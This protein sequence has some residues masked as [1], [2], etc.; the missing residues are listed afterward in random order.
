MECRLSSATLAMDP[1]ASRVVQRFRVAT[2][3]IRELEITSDN[4]EATFNALIAGIDNIEE[5]EKKL[6]LNLRNMTTLMKGALHNDDLYHNGEDVLTHIGWVIDDANRLSANMDA[7]KRVLMK[8]TALCHDL[9]KAYTHAW[10]PDRQKHTFHEHGTKS[11]A[12][13]E[14]LLAK[15]KEQLG[16]LYQDIL[17][18]TRLH[19]VF[20]ALLHE[21]TQQQPGSTKYLAKFMQEAIVQKGLIRDL[22]NFARADSFRARTH[23]QKMKDFEG[24]LDD[25]ERAK[26]APQEEAAA[27]ARLQ[28]N[29]QERMPQ[30]K[31]YLEV[32]APEA[33]ALLPNLQEAKRTLGKMRRYD[34]LKGLDAIVKAP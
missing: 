31:A 19:D 24:V 13:A 18:F 5:V 12:I 17:D 25:L 7:E 10:D 26:L 3:D 32:E 6:G 1:L 30:I 21:R 16:E 28:Q 22:L 20:Y 4:L 27:K 15:H 2:V 14:A 11:V 23:E 34:L 8:L 29:I 33:A 9:G